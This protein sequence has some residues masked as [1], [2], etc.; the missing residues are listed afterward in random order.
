MDKPNPF[1]K[2]GIILISP[3]MKRNLSLLMTIVV[4]INLL[5][6]SCQKK[7]GCTDPN[8]LNQDIVAEVN[9]GSCKYSNATFYASAGFFNGIPIVKIDVTV[10]G[11]DIGTISAIYSSA[12]GNCSA[13]GTVAYQFSDGNKIDWNTTVYLASG[14]TVSGSGQVSPSSVS[15]CIK[16]NV[17]R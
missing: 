11:R 17:T 1:Y 13:Q 8:A 15:D 4:A 6:S 12:P 10:N 7:K 3:I 16:V 14:A 2:V 9:D 5:F